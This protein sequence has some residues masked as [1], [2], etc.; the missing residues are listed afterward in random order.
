MK[1]SEVRKL[2]G[3]FISSEQRFI[4]LQPIKELEAVK[5][6]TTVQLCV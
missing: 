6:E 1:E 2:C 3:Y 4:L 5:P